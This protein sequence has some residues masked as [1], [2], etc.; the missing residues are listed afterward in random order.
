MFAFSPQTT[1]ICLGSLGLVFNYKL[2]LRTVVS[3]DLEQTTPNIRHV[4]NMELIES[5]YTWKWR[6]YDHKQ[7]Q[8][9]GWLWWFGRYT[10]FGGSIMS[11]WWH[12]KLLWFSVTMHVTVFFHNQSLIDSCSL[13]ANSVKLFCGKSA[14]KSTCVTASKH[15]TN[16][17]RRP[18][19]SRCGSAC[20]MAQAWNM[21]QSLRQAKTL[22]E[23]RTP[24][25]KIA[26]SVRHF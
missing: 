9:T 2:D 7:C 8:P 17:T 11:Y 25:K 1:V 13:V 21:S 23:A 24:A 19:S 10:L 20:N 6:G 3:F 16:N 4:F 15:N 22:Q 18:T 14:K 26:T 5:E 12:K